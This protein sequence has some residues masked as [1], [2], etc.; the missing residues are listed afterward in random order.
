MN[1]RLPVSSVHGISPAKIL[2]WVPFPSPGDLPNPET[3]PS[4]PTLVGRFFTT[5]P[6]GKPNLVYINSIKP[7]K[8]NFS[9]KFKSLMKGLIAANNLYLKLLQT[10]SKDITGKWQTNYLSRKNLQQSTSKFNSTVLLKE[11]HTTTNW[12]LSQECKNSSTQENQYN[13]NINR[14]K[15]KKNTW[16]SQQTQ[17][18]HFT[19]SKTFSW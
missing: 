12:D 18:K 4:S 19:K 16:L 6:P 11:L 13:T 8:K 15:G 14:A 9:T 10:P 2:E 3:E 7:T 17:K 5:E 1:C